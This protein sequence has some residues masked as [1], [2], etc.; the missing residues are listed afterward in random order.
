[1][2]FDFILDFAIPHGITVNELFTSAYKTASSLILPPSLAIT[3][4]GQDKVRLIT[5]NMYIVA[6]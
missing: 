4:L 5:G 6:E 1:M 3:L 2:I